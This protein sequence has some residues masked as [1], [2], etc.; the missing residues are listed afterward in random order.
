MAWIE[1]MLLEIGNKA[2]MYY[3]LC[4][5]G[6]PEFFENHA[7]QPSSGTSSTPGFNLYKSQTF[8]QSTNPNNNN[9][10][11]KRGGADD[12]KKSYSDSNLRFAPNGTMIEH[13][14][15]Q[16]ISEFNSNDLEIIEVTFMIS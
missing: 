14:R 9:N 7:K 16:F 4:C 11:A 5:V 2:S 13:W 15:N 6:V 8:G 12:P 1:W 10:N 3:H